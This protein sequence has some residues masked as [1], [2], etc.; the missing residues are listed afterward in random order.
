MFLAGDEF[1]NTQFGNNNAY[2]QDNITSW[3]D[4]NLLEKNR[5]IFT[6]FQYM[7][8]FRKEH[9]V[10]RANV[11]DGCWGLPDV[12]FCGVNGHCGG[13]GEHDRYVGVLFTGGERG[14]GPQA[15]YVASNAWWEELYVHL[16]ELPASANWTLVVDTWEET[17]PA[18]RSV[19][20]G[21]TIRPRSVMVFVGR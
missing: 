4:W 17:V 3:L 8:R 1:G 12:S 6:F 2:C 7:I 18:P 5:D 16:P 15:V 13:F 11:S 21:F 14:V 10:L 19:S 9:R 20:G